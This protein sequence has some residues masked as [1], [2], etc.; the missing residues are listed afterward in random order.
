M[1]TH[2]ITIGI[3]PAELSANS[4]AH[5]MTIARLRKVQHEKVVNVIR[6]LH[7]ELEGAMWDTATIKYVFHWGVNRTRDDDNS[8]SRMKAARDAF[9]PTLYWKSGKKAGQ[10]RRLGAGVIKDDSGFTELPLEEHIDAGNPRVEIHIT[11]TTETPN[12]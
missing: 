11:N 2:I 4:N 6:Y 8:S 10:V 7:P 5:Y 3:P 1:K 9:G 12:D